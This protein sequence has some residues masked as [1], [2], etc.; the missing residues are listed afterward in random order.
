[1]WFGDLVT[2]RWW[3]DL[4]LNESFAEWAAHHSLG[5]GDAV[6]RRV[7]RLH[8]RPQELGLPAG[9][10]AVDPPD[11]RRQPRPARPSRSTSTASPTP[12]ARR[13]SSSWSPGSARRSSSPGCGRTSRSTPAATPS[14]TDL[15]G[16]AG[17]GVGPRPRLLGRGVA[18][19]RPAST[20]CAPAFEVDERRRAS[21]R[22]PSSRPRTDDFPT[23]RRHRIAIGLY[24]RR[25]GPAGPPRAGRDRHRG[26][27]HRGAGAGRR[28]AARPACCSTTTTSPTPRSGSTSA[29][30]RRWSTRIDTFDDSLPRALCWGAAWDMTRDAEMAAAR[31]RRAGAAR[32]RHRDRPRPPSGRCCARRSARST[33]YSDAG[34]TRPS[35]PSAGRPACAALLRGRRA[36]QRPP[37]GASPARTPARRHG[38]GWTSLRAARRQQPRRA[39]ASTPTCAGRWSRRWLARCGRRAGHRRRA[40][41]RQHHLRPGERRGCPAVRPTGR[42]QG[43]GLA[44]SRRRRRHP[45]RDA[46]QIASAF[47]VPG[48]EELL[49]PYVDR[50]LDM[51]ETI[52][53]EMGVWIG[54]TALVYLFPLANPSAEI[55]AKVDAWLAS[56][57]A[58]CGRDALR[59]RGPRRPRPSPARAGGITGLDAE[60]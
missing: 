35:W 48:Q 4:W 19:D 1:M 56:T 9:P 20:R 21:R 2:M 30:W 58:T 16:G 43:G 57:P 37:A 11:R 44:A 31:L 23:L 5:R 12:R 52:M 14:S 26:R 3:D 28:A 47:Q 15:L 40:R 51:A 45:E 46:R 17:G 7:D 41:P 24:D 42:G 13:R 54:Q 39:R 27:A 36:G 25:D 8:Q 33:L 32:R 10:A 50:Y 53:D 29:R 55:L 6:H 34:R 22:S 38:P 18:A 60:Q 49:E 59:R